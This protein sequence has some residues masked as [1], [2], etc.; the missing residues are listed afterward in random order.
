MK[1]TSKMIVILLLVFTIPMAYMLLKKEV[2]RD[3]P[4]NAHNLS[5]KEIEQFLTRECH[6]REIGFGSGF[7]KDGNVF[8]AHSW[9]G[10]YNEQSLEI[11]VHHN[12]APDNSFTGV[13]I[14]LSKKSDVS[15][16][17]KRETIEKLLKRVFSYHICNGK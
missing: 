1:S 5:I 12:Y 6:L 9:V 15:R 2:G 3:Y 13:R 17:L 16:R 8:N 10:K 7:H 4:D 11:F 14:A